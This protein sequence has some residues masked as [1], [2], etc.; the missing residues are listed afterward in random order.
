MFLI[1]LSINLAYFIRTREFITSYLGLNKGIL[2]SLLMLAIYLLGFYVFDFYNISG[3]FIY[4][5]FLANIAGALILVS[6]ISIGLFYIFP[7]IVG[8]GVFIICLTLTCIFLSTWRL[9]YYIFFRQSLPKKYVLIIGTGKSAK[10][11]C[12]LIKINP[13]YKVIGFIG[14]HSNISK[15]YEKNLENFSSLEEKINNHKIDNIIVTIGAFQSKKVNKIL[16]NCKMKGIKIWDVPTFYELFSNK[17]PVQHI[18]ESWF[19][20]TNGF[21]KLSNN[22]YKKLKRSLDILISF[23]ILITT[24][25]FAL[26]IALAIKLDTKGPIL[27]IQERIGVN[28]KPFKLLKFRTMKSDA[29]KGSPVWAK[30]NDP[31]VT[32]TGK[33]IRKIRL[34]EL[35]QLINIIK[36]EMSLIGPRPERKY[37]VQKLMKKIPYY[38]LRFSIKPGLTGWAQVAF[39]YGDSIDDALEKLQY[40]LYYIKNMSLL[41]D[42]RILLK[43][44]RIIL[45][46]M[47]R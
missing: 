18:N 47:G 7:F 20:F 22:V 37:F 27:F 44:I 3:K 13:E 29:E 45:F 40:E 8:R 24:F 46:G 15:S 41:L 42:F 12:S 34:D 25:P 30:E 6:I 4:T 33:I 9:F 21:E 32:R 28:Q 17:I 5:K 38:S 14:I 19:L 1:I 16:I 43:T 26:I 10:E 36:G 31:R 11:I 2:T 35:P 23:I 39:K